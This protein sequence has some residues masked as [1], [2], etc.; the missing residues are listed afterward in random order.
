MAAPRSPSSSDDF[1]SA[2]ALHKLVAGPRTAHSPTAPSGEGAA[3]YEL[4][5]DLNRVVERGESAQ[6]MAAAASGANESDRHEHATEINEGG[7]VNEPESGR[8]REKEAAWDV[9]K[10][11]EVDAGESADLLGLSFSEADFAGLEESH[12]DKDEEYGI[13]RRHV[14][15]LRSE[16]PSDDE[17]EIFTSSPAP[18]KRKRDRKAEK[19]GTYAPVIDLVDDIESVSLEEAPV[20]RRRKRRRRIDDYFADESISSDESDDGFVCALW[21]EY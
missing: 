20:K 2:H 12:E 16:Y 10:E 6:G 19:E 14:Q 5:C 15:A 3:D 11:R 21:I 13:S 8:E 1:L 18:K 7:E 4:M 9:K 17:E